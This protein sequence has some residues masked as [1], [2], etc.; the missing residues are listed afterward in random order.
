MT[1]RS[2]LLTATLLLGSFGNVLA[3]QTM[4]VGDYVVTQWTVED[5]LPSNVFRHMAKSPDG[6]LWI[7]T[8]SGLARF[9]GLEF[10]TYTS[11]DYPLLGSGLMRSLYVETDG[12]ILIG[13]HDQGVL[14]YRNGIIENIPGLPQDGEVGMITRDP[15]GS[16]WVRWNEQ[17]F[18]FD[19]EGPIY[20]QDPSGTRDIAPQITLIPQLEGVEIF[21]TAVQP[22]VGLWIASG[23]GVWLVPFADGNLDLP[24]AM[25][26]A[27]E[28]P[29]VGAIDARCVVADKDAVWIGTESQGLLRFVKPIALEA[30]VTVPR[31]DYYLSL[32]P[33]WP[34]LVGTLYGESDTLL[35]H[36]V[37]GELEERIA[38]LPSGPLTGTNLIPAA[39]AGL[40]ISHSRGLALYRHGTIEEVLSEPMQAGIY[41]NV[42]DGEFWLWTDGVG[43]SST[44]VNARLPQDGYRFVETTSDG[45]RWFWSPEGIARDDGKEMDYFLVKDGCPKGQA[46][47]FLRDRFGNIWIST[48]GTGLGLLVGD[49]IQMIT[50]AQGLPNDILG[51]ILADDADR[52]WINS[53]NGIFV[54]K[55]ADLLAVAAGDAS[56][57][58]CRLVSTGETGGQWCFKGD[59]G[60]LYFREIE[61]Y[62]AIDP[63]RFPDAPTSPVVKV[64]K[65]RSDTQFY[66]LSEQVQTQRG[67][68]WIEI[69]YVAPDLLSA[70][71]TRYRYRIKGVD[72]D[73][74]EAGSRRVATYPNMHPGKHL[75]EVIATAADGQWSGHGD[76]LEFEI[77][78]L[79]HETVWFRGTAIGLFIL[80][81]I[82]IYLVRVRMLQKNM[83]RLTT[84]IRARRRAE[85]RLRNLGQ[86]LISTQEDER[87]NIARELHDN[88]SQRLALIS[89]ELD[90]A[91]PEST[92]RL[93]ALAESAREISADIRALSHSLHPAKLE[94]LGL[95]KSLKGLCRE[96]GS[97]TALDTTSD[98]RGDIDSF[99]PDVAL[100][101]YR[102]A[103]EA[104]GN[105]A[106]HSGSE[107][108][109]LEAHADTEWFTLTVADGGKGFQPEDYETGSL[110]L[111]S[112]AERATGVGGALDIDSSPGQ[113]TTLTARIPLKRDSQ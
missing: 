4:Q 85:H 13:T 100:C 35:I 68:R 110:G 25:L 6:F 104:L 59:D 101:I 102:I 89:I 32:A 47:R 96:I 79:F 31:S 38:T 106:R 66:P 21:G 26:L 43:H 41:S 7:A 83:D 109:T 1:I 22:D 10:E 12:S 28:S 105:V 33:D 58:P 15:D 54:A 84:E 45:T 17:F 76:S 18:R 90:M 23:S 60:M 11:L 71:T 73:W 107:W 27:P 42:G 74:T 82:V 67:E 87:K 51:G 99:S 44:D 46:R 53:N 9:D 62:L 111:V 69:S 92:D 81:G 34:W 57:V 91:Q 97:S 94:Q 14:R 86:Q 29:S 40:W 112:M 16:L 103:Q 72:P 55:I 108:A 64:E 95:A 48:R 8:L 30:P 36:S 24:K 78:Y 65:I 49:S 93:P 63:R 2:L 3:K 19:K 61:R 77:P 75:F 98:L 20:T 39:G 80:T 70:A 88:V 50:T 56:S 52:L 5:G 113:G 37:D